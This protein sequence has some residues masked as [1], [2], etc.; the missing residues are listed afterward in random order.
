VDRLVVIRPVK[1]M[2]HLL[3]TMGREIG[4][5]RMEVWNDPVPEEGDGAVAQP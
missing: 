3:D 5:V 2:G 1:R 4:T